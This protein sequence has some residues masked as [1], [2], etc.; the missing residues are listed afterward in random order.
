MA[1][2]GS[3]T[4]TMLGLA[5]ERKYGTYGSGTISF[6][7]LMTD[8][9]NGGGANNFPALNTQCLP[10]PNISAPH[11]FN[12]WYGYDQD[13]TPAPTCD[14]FQLKY[15][16][17]YR[18]GG[19]ACFA[20][21]VEVAGDSKNPFGSSIYQ[22]GTECSKTAPAGAYAREDGLGWGIWSGSAWTSLGPCFG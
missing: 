16:A 14:V 1:V 18:Q 21:F 8:L 19:D 10:Y 2:P 11:S 13:C 3:G 15:T 6:S 7:I 5:Q 17:K 22:I 9:I 20:G 12:E 4:L